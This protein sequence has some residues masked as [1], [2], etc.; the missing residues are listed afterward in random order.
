MKEELIMSLISKKPICPICGHE[1][2]WISPI[3]IEG[4][5]LCSTCYNKLDID[6][7]KASHMTIQDFKEY[8]A[9]Y[10]Q[11]Q[12]LKKQFVISENIDF[13]L[14]NTKITFDYQNKLFCMRKNPDRTIFEGK[15]LKSFII[16]E[17]NTVIFEGSAESIRR[18]VSTVPERTKALAPQITQF[19]I[20]KQLTSSI[21]DLKDDKENRP[22]ALKYFNMPEPFQAFSIELYFDHPYWTYIKCNINGPR[23]SKDL[24]DVSEYINM[25]HDSIK[26]IEKLVRALKTVAFPDA[27]E[28]SI[29]FG[30]SSPQAEH[31]IIA[32]TADIMKEIKKYKALIEDSIISRYEYNA[33][34]KQRLVM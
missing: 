33:K 13:G 8:L 19:M 10:D 6:N 3:K 16:K 15:Q 20:D 34:K 26:E 30:A 17:D 21:E 22:A 18:Y 27:I 4:Q 11:N 5:Y 31:T 9:F 25:Y 7:D 32:P 23:F 2:P 28:L 1:I 12:L 29:G 24:P 14:W